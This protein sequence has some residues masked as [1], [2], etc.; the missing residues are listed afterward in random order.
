VASAGRLCAARFGIVEFS[1]KGVDLFAELDHLIGKELLCRDDKQLDRGAN[2]NL[3]ERTSCPIECA[4]ERLGRKATRSPEL[5]DVFQALAPT[6][7]ITRELELA[8]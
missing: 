7:S 3:V 4:H 2:A 6:A 8:G 1:S 5:L